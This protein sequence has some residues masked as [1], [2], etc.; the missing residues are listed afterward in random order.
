M[1]P[2]FV[3]NN[4]SERGRHIPRARSQMIYKR[5]AHLGNWSVSK[6]L[7]KQFGRKR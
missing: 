7:R 3:Y 2:V 4:E 6:W 5:D 1:T